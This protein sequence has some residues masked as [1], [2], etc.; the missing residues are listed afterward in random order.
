MVVAGQERLHLL[1]GCWRRESLLRIL[2]LLHNSTYDVST[3]HTFSQQ[4]LKPSEWACKQ[5]RTPK[6]TQD[7]PSAP[8]APKRPRPAA[9]LTSKSPFPHLPSPPDLKIAGNSIFILLSKNFF[10]S[11][12]APLPNFRRSQGVPAPSSPLFWAATKVEKHC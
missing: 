5:T 4:L 12:T 7:Q 2:A 9:S 1:S 3:F 8:S 10:L 11:Y 6:C